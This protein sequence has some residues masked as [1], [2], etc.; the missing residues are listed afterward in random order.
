M[1]SGL[2]WW[3]TAGQW[4]GQC[5]NLG[6]LTPEPVLVKT[7]SWE[8]SPT[9]SPWWGPQGV[10]DHG[11]A[12]RSGFHGSGLRGL[13][14]RD[15]GGESLGGNAWCMGAPI[16]FC[17]FAISLTILPVGLG[18]VRWSRFSSSC[19][20]SCPSNLAVLCLR[21]LWQIATPSQARAGP[22]C[23]LDDNLSLTFGISISGW[24]LSAASS[25]DF[26]DPPWEDAPPEW[27]DKCWHI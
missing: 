4:Q 20:P 2:S 5:L 17:P 23:H 25:L 7:P 12:R 14:Q 8:A 3:Q 22:S 15:E 27:T 21:D 24:I 6:L 13:G 11:G 26:Q 10:G 16:H 19:R 9:D 1:L 18:E